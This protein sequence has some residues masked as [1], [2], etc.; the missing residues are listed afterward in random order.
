[1]TPYPSLARRTD[2]S[3]NFGDVELRREDLR[4]VLESEFHRQ[5]SHSGLSPED[6]GL[7]V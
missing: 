7:K 6:L 1:M 2:G 3:C 4:E 5:M